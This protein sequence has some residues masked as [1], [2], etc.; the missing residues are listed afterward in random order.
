MKIWD[1][2]SHETSSLLFYKFLNAPGRFKGVCSMSIR[3]LEEE[4]IWYAYKLVSINLI[5][6]TRE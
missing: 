3:P 4:I 6:G 1:L 5:V 2:I